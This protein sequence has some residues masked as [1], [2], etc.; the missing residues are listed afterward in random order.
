VLAFVLGSGRG[1]VVYEALDLP[2]SVTC[3]FLGELAA[4]N[5]ALDD[6]GF[7]AE[8]LAPIARIPHDA[9]WADRL[10]DVLGG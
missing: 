5:R 6:A 9:S 4:V 2:E 1:Y 10:A 7:R 3:V 8:D